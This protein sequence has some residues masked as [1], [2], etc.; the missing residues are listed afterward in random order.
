MFG[1]AAWGAFYAYAQNQ[2]KISSSV[3]KQIL[4]IVRDNAELQELLGEAIRPEPAWYL[5]GDPW[6]T[7]AV[8]FHFRSHAFLLCVLT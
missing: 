8:S 2:E 5:N 1:C 6:I 4:T 3:F 7:G